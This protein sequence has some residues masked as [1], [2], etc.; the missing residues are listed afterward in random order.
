MQ[1]CAAGAGLVGFSHPTFSDIQASPKELILL[2]F[3]FGHDGFTGK[4][5]PSCH[6]LEMPDLELSK[7]AEFERK[8][9]N[10]EVVQ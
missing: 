5:N 7:A 1:C 4:S 3:P 2:S 10:A 6:W 8:A 9:F